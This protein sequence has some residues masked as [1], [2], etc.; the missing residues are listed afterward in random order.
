MMAHGRDPVVPPSQLRDDVPVDLE[1]VILT[2]LAKKRAERYQSVQD[3]D[4][5]LASCAA[6]AD[7]DRAK[8]RE[9]WA[10]KLQTDAPDAPPQAAAIKT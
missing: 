2:C 3:L 7:W 8:A 5:A 4:D 10:G 9:W 1:R 6:A